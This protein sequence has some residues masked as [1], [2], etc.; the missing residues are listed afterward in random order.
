[1]AQKRK[2]VD[3]L[4]RNKRAK[5]DAAD[6]Q[7][8]LESAN[9]LSDDQAESSGEFEENHDPKPSKSSMVAEIKDLL[10]QAYDDAGLAT[11]NPN[12]YDIVTIP[13]DEMT[14]APGS[15]RFQ[16]ILHEEEGWSAAQMLDVIG[17]SPTPISIYPLNRPQSRALWASLRYR[18]HMNE[19]RESSAYE[20]DLPEKW[21]EIK[22]KFKDFGKK[23]A[24]VYGMKLAAAVA[25]H[26][27]RFLGKELFW[28]RPLCSELGWKIS[29]TFEK[30]WLISLFVVCC[31]PEL[32][33]TTINKNWGR[34]KD[35]CKEAMK[36]AVKKAERDKK[37]KYKQTLKLFKV[38]FPTVL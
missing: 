12:I 25:F 20:I 19:W 1:M 14:F 31:S 16:K 38:L 27:E 15:K 30:R 4:E 10:K 6:M 33:E 21:L 24:K 3:G 26:H 8:D 32:L 28:F 29:E 37:V 34:K 17:G 2:Q 11:K 22:L 23:S 5:S 36:Q 18:L 13:W 9:F 35:E 7:Q